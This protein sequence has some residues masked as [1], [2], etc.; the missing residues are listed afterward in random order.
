MTFGTPLALGVAAAAALVT[1][2]LHFI[3]TRRP[4]PSPLPTARFVDDAT[5]RAASRAIQLSDAWLLVLRVLALLALGAGF[6]GPQR[7]ASPR[8]QAIWLV[9]RSRAVG[10]MDDVRR[11]ARVAPGDVVVLFDSIA[12]RVPADSLRAAQRVDVRGSLSAAVAAA[13]RETARAQ[14]RA[15]VRGE[16]VTVIVVS[17]SAIEEVD[18]AT[19]LLRASVRGPVRWVRVAPAEVPPAE[20]RTVRAATS[21]DSLWARAGA[22]VLVLWPRDSVPMAAHAVSAEGTTLVSLLGRSAVGAGVATARWED[23]V[24]A[25]V[26]RA[27]GGGCVREVGVRAPEAGDVQLSA[28]FRSFDATLSA[29][30]GSPRFDADTAWLAPSRAAAPLT[31]QPAISSPWAPWLMALGMLLLVAELYVRRRAVP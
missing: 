19:A 25:V 23:G 14:A 27:L 17:P 28:A 5:A 6:A 22:R 29:P 15:E 7:A 9:D 3:A 10:S 1:V 30:C 18:S 2:A 11:A 21:A 31:L 20:R 16:R 26:E 24:P 12:R 4:L 13:L 8:A